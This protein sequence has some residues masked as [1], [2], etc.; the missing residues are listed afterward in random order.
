MIPEPDVHWLAGLLEGEGSFLPGLPSKPNGPSISIAMVDEDVINRAA[1]LLGVHHVHTRKGTGRSQD[2]YQLV[3]RGRKAVEVMHQLYPLMGVRRQGQI[4]R[5]LASHD[6][7]YRSHR[8]GTLSDAQV[9][10]VYRRAHAGESLKII[11]KDMGV[12]RSICTDIKLGRTWGWLTGHSRERQ[13]H[14]G[15]GNEKTA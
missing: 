5:A 7:H 1:A 12:S 9:L 11:A 8:Q 4:E 3:L 10:E 15:D 6:P 14:A 2:S 13:N